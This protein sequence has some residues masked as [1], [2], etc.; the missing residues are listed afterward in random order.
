MK[1]SFVSDLLDED[2]W[3]EYLDTGPDQVQCRLT[4]AEDDDKSLKISSLVAQEHDTL[5]TSKLVEEASE[6]H[7]LLID[8]RQVSRLQ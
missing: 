8:M 7:F 6:D 1:D 2:G 5:D 4:V 3:G